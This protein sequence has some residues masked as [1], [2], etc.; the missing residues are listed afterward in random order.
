MTLSVTSAF[1]AGNIRVLAIHDTRV[2][3][4]IVRDHNS[5]FF[6]WFHFRLSGA[7]GQT[8][9]L[10]ITNCGDSAYPDGWPGY[11]ARVSEDRENWLL[12]ETEY[13][14]GQLT[15][16]VTPTC[17]A[18]WVAY[19][20]PYSM[21]R[22]HDVIAWAASQPGVTSRELGRTLDGQPL[23]MLTLGEGAKQVWLYARQHPGET[24]AEWWMEGGT[25]APLRHGRQRDT[26]A[27]ATRH[28][29]HH[30]E[31]E[32][33]WQQAR[34]PSHQCSR[35]KPQPGMGEPKHGKQPGSFRRPG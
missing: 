4:E 23:D 17:D 2:E 9:T 26:T 6:Q 10:V 3:L 18:L 20:A 33:G 28:L 31:Y 25:R 1:D 19:F 35:C 21:E 22:H 34:P 7:A 11:K 30:P 14:N 5:D 27:S 8:V 32:P 15:I 13:R 29:S 24:M 12:A 16:R